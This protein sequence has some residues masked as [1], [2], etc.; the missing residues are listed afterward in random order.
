MSPRELRQRSAKIAKTEGSTDA[1][2]AGEGGAAAD[3]PMDTTADGAAADAAPEEVEE[4]EDTTGP[5]K[6]DVLKC[7]MG[8]YDSTSAITGEDDNGQETNQIM[9]DCLEFLNDMLTKPDDVRQSLAEDFYDNQGILIL[10][11]CLKQYYTQSRFFVQTMLGVINEISA[12]DDRCHEFINKFNAVTVILTAATYHRSTFQA[13]KETKSSGGDVEETKAAEDGA[14]EGG[15][16][17][18]AATAEGGEAAAS[19]AAKTPTKKKKRKTT[20][21]NMY[22]DPENYHGELLQKYAIMFLVNLTLNEDEDIYLQAC[23]EA[24]VD[25]VKETMTTYFDKLPIQSTCTM[26]FSELSR[27]EGD[28][29]VMKNMLLDKNIDQMLRDAFHLFRG[30]TNVPGNRKKDPYGEEKALA[31]EALRRLYK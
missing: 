10:L 1:A 17:A 19:A 31:Q 23:T 8:L 6:M 9:V 18:A 16:D 5:G 26:Y 30:A 20:K 22:E 7:L 21:K 29:N 28:D 24:C 2:T 11:L 4:E 14:G 27:I 12:F 25:F 13:D 15:G 3:T